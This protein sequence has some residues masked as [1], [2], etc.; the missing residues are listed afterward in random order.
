[1][2]SVYDRIFVKVDKKWND[3]ITTESGITFFK[4]TTFR[5]EHGVNTVGTVIS[6]PLKIT[7]SHYPES[8]VINV[9]DGDKLHFLYLAAMDPENWME[10]EGQ[11][12]LSVDYFN[13][14]AIERDGEL[15]PV[16]SYILIEPILESYL[17][18]SVITI[19]DYLKQKEK[20]KG[21]VIA[22]NDPIAIVNTVVSFDETGKY[23]MDFMG[24]TVYA[25]LNDNLYFVHDK[26]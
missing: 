2:Q 12:L 9:R 13:A 11:E 10:L 14:I 15:I 7:R 23:D 1:M 20:L 5:P 26:D 16:G 17:D 8:F 18:S 6:A 19:P 22:S 21:R 25:A 3:E 4:D 24:R